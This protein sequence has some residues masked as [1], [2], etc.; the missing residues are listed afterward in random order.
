M[1]E[2]NAPRTS[3]FKSSETRPQ[4]NMMMIRAANAADA[5]L[6][7][8]VRET[9]DDR[10]RRACDYVASRCLGALPDAGAA[11]PGDADGTAGRV[12]AES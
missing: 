11:D 7:E 12:S 3:D 1:A 9:F 6:Y 4:S 2:Y 5:A 10:L 8:H